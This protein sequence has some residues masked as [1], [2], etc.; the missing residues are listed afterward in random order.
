MPCAI[1]VPEP[2]WREMAASGLLFGC[3][4]AKMACDSWDEGCSASWNFHQQFIRIT[5]SPDAVFLVTRFGWHTAASSRCCIEGSN[6][7]AGAT[8]HRWHL[9]KC[10]RNNDLEG[11]AVPAGV[12]YP[13]VL[14]WPTERTG[15]RPC[16]RA[17]R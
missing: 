7:F 15:C 11:V 6:R 13:G 14:S 5:D 17:S 8:R 1:D 10:C 4:E 3:H 12:L 9:I 2:V 16:P